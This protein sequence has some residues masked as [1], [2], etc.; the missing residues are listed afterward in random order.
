VKDPVGFDVRFSI[1]VEF[2]DAETIEYTIIDGNRR[3]TAYVAPE[4]MAAVLNRQIPFEDL[5]TGYMAEWKRE[6]VDYYNRS[7]PMAV[8]GFG[9]EYISS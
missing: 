2:P 9:Y 7:L 8:E 5:S 1:I 6:P 4:I 3:K